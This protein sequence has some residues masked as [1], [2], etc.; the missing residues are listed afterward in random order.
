MHASPATA[1]CRPRLPKMPVPLCSVGLGMRALSRPMIFI[2]IL[3]VVATLVGI[4]YAARAQL[5]NGW[6]SRNGY[7]VKRDIA[8]G[9]LPRQKLDL[10]APDAGLDTAP[11]IVFFYGSGWSDGSKDLYRFVAQPFASRGF[12][13]AVPDHRLF[14]EVTFPGFVEDG[15][16]AVAYL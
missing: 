7:S 16:R 13:V 11:L 3:G 9:D 6:T 15:A 14:P 12:L 8:Y 4:A 2:V 5:L 10:Y 1:I